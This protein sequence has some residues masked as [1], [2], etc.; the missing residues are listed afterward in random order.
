MKIETTIL[1]IT[2]LLPASIFFFIDALHV[3]FVPAKKSKDRF[4]CE[5]MYKTPL[6]YRCGFKDKFGRITNGVLFH[7]I[8]VNISGN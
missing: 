8:D 5:V 4:H 3:P 7:T 1:A 2:F 6:V